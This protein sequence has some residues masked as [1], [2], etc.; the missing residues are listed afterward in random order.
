VAPLRPAGGR[1][2]AVGFRLPELRPARSWTACAGRSRARNALPVEA[3]ER[4]VGRWGVDVPRPGGPELAAATTWFVQPGENRCQPR[5]ALGDIG[6]KC[7]LA[8]W[9]EDQEDP[10]A[11]TRPHPRRAVRV[12]GKGGDGVWTTASRPG[13]AS[14]STARQGRPSSSLRRIPVVANSSHIAARRSSLVA[15]RKARSSSADQ[16]PRSLRGTRGG[17]AASATLRA[18]RPQRTASLSALCSST[19]TWRTVLGLRPPR[20]SRRPCSARLA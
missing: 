12:G 10:A 18:A 19:W 20:P 6:Q 13:D 16:A 15:S 8:G 17:S 11:V 2:R 4:V 7:R 5:V 1:D 3:Q 9:G 14:R